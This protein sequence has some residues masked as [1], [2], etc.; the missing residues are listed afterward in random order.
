MYS[1][2][3]NAQN[4]YKPDEFHLI[5]RI[6]Y[7]YILIITFAISEK[8][9]RGEIW[10]PLVADR[11]IL[12][13]L[14]SSSAL[15]L[16]RTFLFLLIH[17][18]SEDTLLGRYIKMGI[19]FMSIIKL[20]VFSSFSNKTGLSRRVTFNVHLLPW[21]WSSSLALERSEDNHFLGILL[22]FSFSVGPVMADKSF[23]GSNRASTI[24]LKLLSLL[25]SLTHL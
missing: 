9:H 19:A 20:D 22:A 25:N 15:F 4:F 7:T 10:N 8:T 12:E 11:N 3:L 14:F 1:A 24:V 5:L 16:L 23:F 2:S 6:L 21:P 13:T 17:S 18:V